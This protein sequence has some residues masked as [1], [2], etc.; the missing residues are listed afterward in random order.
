MF[1][2]KCAPWARSLVYDPNARFAAELLS[3]SCIWADEHTTEWCMDCVGR[4][5]FLFHARYC[6][7]VGEPVTPEAQALWDQAEREFPEWP[8]FRPERRS[9]AI[10]DEVRRLVDEF[11][12]AELG[13]MLALME[14]EDALP[15]PALQRTPAA[16]TGFRRLLSF[17]G[18]RRAR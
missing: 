7:T 1:C 4:T 11:T 8:F 15:D 14:A 6:M 5:R 16:A 13:P 2:D 17:F 3:G 10:A 18:G 12:E 9:A